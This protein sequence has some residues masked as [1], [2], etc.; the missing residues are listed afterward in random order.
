MH[1]RHGRSN[2][3]SLSHHDGPRAVPHSSRGPAWRVKQVPPEDLR[4]PF[5]RAPGEDLPRVTLPGGARPQW[6]TRGPRWVPWWLRLT[7][8]RAK[9][10]RPRLS[11]SASE[12][13][14]TLPR[15]A[16]S[17][18][19]SIALTCSVR[20]SSCDLRQQGPGAEISAHN[21][22]NPGALHIPNIAD[23]AAVH[24]PLVD[25]C[26]CK[27]VPDPIGAG[28]NTCRKFRSLEGSLGLSPIELFDSLPAKLGAGI[29]T[30]REAESSTELCNS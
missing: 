3:P 24:R 23:I 8:C 19:A 26:V 18:G 29:G 25:V 1:T 12:S 15:A 30:A 10:Q 14:R 22:K 27:A 13:P 17:A 21:S 5:G 16:A 11:C 7:D 2:G 9:M 20:P 4:R 6:A 28:M